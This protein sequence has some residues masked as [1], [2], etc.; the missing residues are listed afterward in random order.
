MSD[1]TS[2]KVVFSIEGI[3]KTYDADPLLFNPFSL[4]IY[5]GDKIGVIGNNGLGK[6][7]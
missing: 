3:S 2:G 6:Q 5:Q 7:L 1:K 4:E